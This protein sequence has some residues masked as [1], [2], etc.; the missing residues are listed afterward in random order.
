MG[1]QQS[2]GI[3][4]EEFVR[5]SLFEIENIWNEGFKGGCLDESFF[6]VMKK[7]LNRIAKKVLSKWKNVISAF[8]EGAI[9]GFFI[10]INV[11]KTTTAKIVRVIREGFL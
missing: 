2:I 10:M 1:L 8:R 11:F 7:R 9:S 6:T 3:M 5:A 4:L